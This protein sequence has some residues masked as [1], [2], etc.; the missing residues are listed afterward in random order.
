M[1]TIT[2]KNEQWT[3][4]FLKKRLQKTSLRFNLADCILPQFPSGDA[5]LFLLGKKRKICL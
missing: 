3:C 5:F 2:L 1:R 4:V